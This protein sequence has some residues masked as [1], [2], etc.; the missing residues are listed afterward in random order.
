MKFEVLRQHHGDKLYMPGDTREASE[1]EVKHLVDAG[2]LKRGRESKAEAKAEAKSETASA[3]KAEE[4]APK[5]KAG[6]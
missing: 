1:S 4:S 3:N 2:V 5:N 6:K